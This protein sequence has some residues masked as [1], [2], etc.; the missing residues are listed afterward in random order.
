MRG[1]KFVLYLIIGFA[2]FIWLVKVP[3]L[4][5]YFSEKLGLFVSIEWVSIWP[6]ESTFRGLKI[7]NPKGFHPNFALEIQEVRVDYHLKTFFAKPSI[8][9]QISCEHLLL[10]VDQN[11]W[12]VLLQSAKGEGSL[13]VNKLVLSDLTIHYTDRGG[14]TT[15]RHIDRMDF[16]DI[17]GENGFPI[18]QILKELI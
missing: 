17:Q 8:I 10:N 12:D 14:Q 18:D 1:W 9:D 16:E 7:H 6:N 15:K 5:H 11:N 3:I 4:S 2:A 13:R